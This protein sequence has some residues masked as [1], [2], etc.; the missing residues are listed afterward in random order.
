MRA[1]DGRSELI[2]LRAGQDCGDHRENRSHR[3]RALRP[4]V[5]K[6]RRAQIGWECLCVCCRVRFVSHAFMS[7][8]RGRGG[9][10][11]CWNRDLR[12]CRIRRRHAG[13][14]PL[15]SSAG[16]ACTAVDGNAQ[17]FAYSGC[18]SAPRQWLFSSW[19]CA[20]A[21][22]SCGRGRLAQLQRTDIGRNCPAIFRRQL[23]RVVRH[24]SIAVRHHV[25]VVR[26]RL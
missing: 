13:K 8:L 25:E 17:G 22:T 10:F 5:H 6:S 15:L 26:D 21:G 14:C 9:R 7:L 2:R 20:P 16:L 18:P 24:C 4:A 11:T 23:R 12:V 3:E 19:T 1:A